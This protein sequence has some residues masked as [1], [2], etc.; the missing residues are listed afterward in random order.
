MRFLLDTQVLLW[1]LTDAPHIESV[2]DLLLADE[3]EV[4]VSIVSWCEIASRIRLGKQDADLQELRA[5]VQESGF[6]ELPFLGVHAIM[7]AKLPPFTIM[8]PL[9]TPW[10]LRPWLS[11]C[12]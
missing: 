7:L 3:N 9:T 10:W 1:A 8:T 12:D 11:L 6:V 5:I 2:K 4:F